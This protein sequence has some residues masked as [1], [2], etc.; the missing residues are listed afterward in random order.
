[1]YVCCCYCAE[2]NRILPSLFIWACVFNLCMGIEDGK[3]V[4]FV[5]YHTALDDHYS[6]LLTVFCLIKLH[7]LSGS[8]L[9]FCLRGG[10]LWV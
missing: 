3:V 4:L 6:Y 7:S 10:E 2:E 8:S 9:L 1:M 5:G